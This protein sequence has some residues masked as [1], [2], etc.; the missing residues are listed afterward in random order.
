MVDDFTKEQYKEF[1]D[2]IDQWILK[3]KNSE[4]EVIRRYIQRTDYFAVYITEQGALSWEHIKIPDFAREGINKYEELA[5]ELH[6]YIGKIHRQ[7]IIA[8]LGASLVQL[9]RATSPH[10]ESSARYFD[11]TEEF[12][13]KI[14]QRDIFFKSDDYYIYSCEING[15]AI[16]QRDSLGVT[17]LVLAEVTGICNWIN[18]ALVG[19]QKTSA[20]GMLCEAIPKFNANK[21]TSE[22]EKVTQYVARTEKSNVS[23]KYLSTSMNLCALFFLILWVLYLGD[24]SLL[25]IPTELYL[26]AL[27]GVVGTSISLLQRS[28]QLD[29]QAYANEVMVSYEAG[30]RAFMGA[31]FGALIVIF[32][33]TGMLITAE[34]AQ[35]NSYQIFIYGVI[36]GVNER[37]I[38]NFLERKAE[39]LEG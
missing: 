21:D 17:D 35:I 3:G 38:P 32:I 15:V 5:A 13:D 30:L 36:A 37:F 23:L 18:H 26:A 29:I 20:Y 25:G 22:F 34:Y 2:T 16:Q 1:K 33:K 31:L 11:S 8:K 27:G 19:K 14:K 7:Q 9:F 28:K 4:G 12:I 24:W 6:T 39:E 10:T